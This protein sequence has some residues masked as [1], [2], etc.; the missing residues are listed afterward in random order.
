MSPVQLARRIHAEAGMVERWLAGAE[1]PGPDLLGKL[2]RVLGVSPEYFAGGDLHIH[3]NAEDMQVRKAF[4]GA[5]DD[6]HEPVPAKERHSHRVPVVSWARAGEG[7]NFGDGAH[8][9]S[10]WLDINCPDP[11]AY[12]LILEGDSMVPEFKPADRVICMPNTTA[13]NGDV[14]VAQ[15]ARSGDVLFKICHLTGPQSQAVCLTS[16]NPAYP[17]LEYR[18]EEFSFIHPVHSLFRVRQR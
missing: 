1:R 5:G 11:N 15:V 9:I 7:G 18:R 12:A 16:Y 6:R 8:P 10:E 14:V 13:Q 17:P 4:W 2:A 3:V